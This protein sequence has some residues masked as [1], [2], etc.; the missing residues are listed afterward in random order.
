[1]SYAQ[2]MKI[3]HLEKLASKASS[4]TSS[5]S[6]VSLLKESGLLPPNITRHEFVIS[7]SNKNEL[8][9]QGVEYWQPNEN[10]SKFL[11]CPTII[12]PLYSK[13]LYNELPPEDKNKLKRKGIQSINLNI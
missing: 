4:N 8:F 9:L 6:L 5:K 3:R 10:R 11:K 7:I 12:A 13:L 2:R 1:M